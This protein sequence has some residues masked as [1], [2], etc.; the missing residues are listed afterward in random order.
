MLKFA[1]ALED[2]GKFIIS[3]AGKIIGTFVAVGI[4]FL[5]LLIIKL[6]VKRFTKNNEGKRKKAI[7][8][9]KL[10]Y[11]VI[12]YILIILLIIIILSIWGVNV[13]P[14][15]VGVGILILAVALS[16]QKL[17]GDYI[18]GLCI[19]IENCYDIDDVVEINGFKGKVDEISLRT[20]KLINWKNE[21]R[22]I[23][24]GKINEIT[25][26]SKAPSIGSVEVSIDKKENIDK[27]I[28]LLE[29]K[30]QIIKERFPQIIE[31]PNVIGVTD[32]NKE[33][34]NIRI[35]VKTEI[36]KHHEVERELKKYI[37]E[38]FDD[39]G[40]NSAHNQ[41]VEINGSNN[42]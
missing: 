27:I 35:N 41:V 15:L 23:R 18:S 7:Q 9:I 40:I 19:I 8:L 17:L 1:S 32:I 22:I 16:S 21:V 38:L 31:G 13:F 4:F 39:G 10:F 34:F 24:N 12:K 28:N 36:E 20:T 42:K 33:S 11:S 25:N 30:I 14:I 6:S 2:F 5:L 29:E 37:K 3:N 26:Y